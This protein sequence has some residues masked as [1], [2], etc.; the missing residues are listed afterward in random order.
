MPR[1]PGHESGPRVGAR[2]GCLALESCR[3]L[4]RPERQIVGKEFPR[5][6]AGRNAFLL[7][8]EQDLQVAIEYLEKK[9]PG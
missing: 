5:V 9:K 8:S 1:R 2:H 3:R 6:F 4:Q 7:E